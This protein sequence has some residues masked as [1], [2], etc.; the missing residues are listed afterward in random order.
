MTQEQTQKT[1]Q[2]ITGLKQLGFDLQTIRRT[3]PA[4]TGKTH[5]HV[6]QLLGVSRTAVTNTMNGERANTQMQERIA[7]VYGVPAEE[8]FEPKCC[9]ARCGR[10]V[11]A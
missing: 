3:L 6:A 1:I 11:A 8:I 10:S 5:P 7:Q 4:L 2:A 9:C